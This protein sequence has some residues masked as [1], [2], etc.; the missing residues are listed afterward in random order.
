MDAVQQFDEFNGFH[1]QPGFFFY[2]P[3][4]RLAQGLA[5]IDQAPRIDHW[6]LRGSSYPLHKQNAVLVHDHAAYANQRHR[7]K[8]SPGH[9]SRIE[10]AIRQQYSAAMDSD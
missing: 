5:H 10:R 4:D 1:I 2:F 6:P 3:N 8:F 7:W 9:N